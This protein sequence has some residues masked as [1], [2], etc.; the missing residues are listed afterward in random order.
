MFSGASPLPWLVLYKISPRKLFQVDKQFLSVRHSPSHGI[1]SFKQ[2]GKLQN[3]HLE[4]R[5]MRKIVRM[6][7]PLGGREVIAEPVSEHFQLSLDNVLEFRERSVCV[8][9]CVF[10]AEALCFE[11]WKTRE[12]DSRERSY[13]PTHQTKMSPA[14]T[15]IT[16][17]YFLQKMGGGAARMLFKV[18]LLHFLDSPV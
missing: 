17:N 13:F 15:N 10:K 6:N 5:D 16:C 4:W 11:R 12:G 7:L 18:R 8:F 9:L 2:F 3:P 14:F 1:K